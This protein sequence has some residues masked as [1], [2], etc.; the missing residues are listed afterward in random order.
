MNE[1]D[2]VLCLGPK[3]REIVSYSLASIKKYVYGYRKVFIISKTDPKLEA[4]FF[5][6]SNFPFSIKDVNNIINVPL[7]AG[8]Y[9]QQ[10][11]KLYV[12]FVLPELLDTFVVIDCDT[13]FLKPITFYQDGKF[14]INSTTNENNLPY[15]EHMQR[16]H[17]SIE[18]MNEKSGVCHHMVFNKYIL[19]EL[20]DLIETRHFNPLW[21]VFLELVD[22]KERGG[23]GASEYEIYFNYV[24]KFHSDKI[25]LRSIPFSGWGADIALI[26]PNLPYNYVNH[27]WWG[28]PNKFRHIDQS[29]LNDLTTNSFL[30]PLIPEHEYIS[31]ERL[32]EI[33]DV[34]FITSEIKN[35]HT[36]LS[37]TTKLFY[38]DQSFTLD[39]LKATLS[40]VKIIFVYTHLI[41]LFIEKVWC[42]VDRP[43]I[44][45]THNSDQC[46]N[47]RYL[48]LIEDQMLVHWFCQN[49]MISHPKITCLPI[50]IANKQWLHGNIETIKNISYL[51][52]NKEN[53]LIVNFNIQTYLKHRIK[54]FNRLCF[55]S[56]V[57]HYQPD[58]PFS[59]YCN[60]LKSHKFSACPRGNGPDTHRLWESLYLGTIPLVDDMANTRHFTD[61]P[62][63]LVKDWT[64]ID[65][66]FIDSYKLNKSFEKLKLSYWFD[67]INFHCNRTLSKTLSLSTQS[68]NFVIAYLGTLPS[69]LKD[70][71]KQIRL[72]NTYQPIFIVCDET[73]YNKSILLQLDLYNVNVVFTNELTKTNSHIGFNYTYSNLS[74]NGFWKYAMERFFL[75]EEVMIKFNLTDVVHLE[76]DNLVYFSLDELLPHFQ[77]INRL[78]APSDNNTRF[79]AG[80]VYIPNIDLLSHL[81]NFFT[82]MNNNVAE[83]EVMMN[84]Y[85]QIKLKDHNGYI[86][87]ILE[88]MPVIMPE[89]NEF[90]FNLIDDP[91]KL[92]NYSLLFNG[93]FDAAAFGQFLGGIDK[94]HNKNN[95]DGFINPHAAY[96]VNNLDIRWVDTLGKKRPQTRVKGG[97]WWNIYNLHIHSKDLFRFVS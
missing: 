84:F 3:D 48:G 11:L 55:Q 40:N 67:Q 38:L 33:C 51:E 41:D 78:L 37:S 85:N 83:M 60:I 76:V 97:E 28:E 13:L 96:Q 27:H 46:I 57:V 56:N 92:S 14:L 22:L 36:S 31:G 69:Y 72:W 50:G 73:V 63:I 19:R 80:L 62:I 45:M 4:V 90:N 18:K 75:V 15:Y 54:V 68:G 79:I 93:I 26:P 81:N 25:V 70:C 89:Y 95:T 6:E 12:S 23:S 65:K 5:D 43:L 39:Q 1:F 88:I 86:S 8:W 20:F 30:P 58:L 16:L 66:Q 87:N 29:I 94:I 47:E 34:S 35:F 52:T 53:K 64:E 24:I 42:Y 82:N 21:K 9:F 61:L 91:K 7:R 10:L 49:A 44:L 32:Q 2:I 77:A 59:N 17:P 74:M 71:V